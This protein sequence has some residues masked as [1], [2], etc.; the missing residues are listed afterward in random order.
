MQENPVFS[1]KIAF[2]RELIKNGSVPQDGQ[3]TIGGLR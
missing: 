2:I 1:I 3:G